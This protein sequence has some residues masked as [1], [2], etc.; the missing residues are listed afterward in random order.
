MVPS[1]DT[2]IPP[3]ESSLRIGD[4]PSKPS[5]VLDDTASLSTIDVSNDLP[6]DL[7]IFM[8]SLQSSTRTTVVL[9]DD[10]APD[11][12]LVPSTQPPATKVVSSDELAPD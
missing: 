8:P 2:S 4:L 10:L 3:V 7:K 5:I 6:P 11:P 9:T 1:T 12:S